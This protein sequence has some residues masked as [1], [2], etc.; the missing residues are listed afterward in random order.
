MY[1]GLH[2]E[3]T[4]FFSDWKETWV[5][6]EDFQKN[7]HISNLMKIRSVGAEL[8]HAGGQMVGRT[9]RQTER[10]TDMTKL[11]VVLRNFAKGA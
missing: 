7:A 3:Y 9:D 4:L 11:F 6:S 5:F 8:L 1:I 10:W 2:A